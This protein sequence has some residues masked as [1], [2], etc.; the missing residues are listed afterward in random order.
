MEAGDQHDRNMAVIRDFLG[1]LDAGAVQAPTEKVATA[2]LDVP[3][4]RQTET[5][6]TTE[7]GIVSGRVKQWSWLA[8]GF[9]VATGLFLAVGGLVGLLLFWPIGLFLLFLSWVSFAL[10]NKG[11]WGAWLGPCPHCRQEI[12]VPDA[13]KSAVLSPVSAICPCCSNPVAATRNQFTAVAAAAPPK[14]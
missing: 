11:L 12:A 1:R 4:P 9:G 10:P 5:R 6:F 14:S 3:P 7:W 13:A 8:A 2:G